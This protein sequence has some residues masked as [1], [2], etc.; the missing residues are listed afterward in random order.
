MPP[1][2]QESADDLK[3]DLRWL[4]HNQASL[5]RR[6]ERVENSLV[7][8]TLRRIGR[9]YSE[10]LAKRPSGAYQTWR[11]LG[12]GAA[13]WPASN[14]RPR[15]SLVVSPGDRE[16]V[17][18]SVQSYCEVETVESIGQ[19]TGDYVA[20]IG[21]RDEIY[22][23]ALE[24][25]AAAAPAD[26][27]YT[28]QE[29]IDQSRIGI[30]PVFKPDWSP[31]L[32]QSVNYLGG[33]TAVRREL[34]NKDGTF[35]MQDLEAVHVPVILYGSPEV[36]TA[37]PPVTPAPPA[38]GAVVSI[39]VCTRMAALLKKCLKGVSARTD[40]PHFEL[41]VVQHLGSSHAAEE[42]AVLGVISEYGAK[43]VPYAGAFNFAAMNNLGAHA[44]AGSVLL[45]MNDDVVPAK[46][47]WLRRMAAWLEQPSVGAV[48]AK[49]TFPDGTL[50]HSGIAAWMIDGAW[51]PGRQMAPTQNWRWTG[52][53]REV[54][55]VTGACLAIRSSDF[56]RLGGFDLEFPVNFND[57]DLCFR[58]GREGYRIL[59]D[60]EA[61]LTHDESR[62][63]GYSGTTYEERRLFFRKWAS[64]LEHTDPF[65]TPHLAQ[66]N[67]DLSL[68]R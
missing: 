44:A 66:N 12:G 28:D 39:I 68:R 67:E 7:F 54:S 25:L 55:A 20:S 58:L 59:V 36:A 27:I 13:A 29:V 30:A 40:Y 23:G 9:L 26:L 52:Y 8:R 10:R 35:Q 17:T 5:D 19:A 4:L 22:P 15:F 42:A 2:E 63:R 65:Y 49:L 33:L 11:K 3:A 62:T 24:H 48:G 18:R 50:Q 41:V 61:E 21:E 16:R 47:D 45:F 34:L 6:L 46:P 32:F 57:V 43:R 53:T 60:V 51:H 31:V 37:P 1:G 14:Q 56:Q 38:F 64:R